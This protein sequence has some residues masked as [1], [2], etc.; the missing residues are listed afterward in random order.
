MESTKCEIPAEKVRLYV[1]EVE[2]ARSVIRRPHQIFD[3]DE[4]GFCLRRI[5]AKKKG[6]VYYK[7]CLT[8]GAFR[9]RPQSREPGGNDPSILAKI[10]TVLS[11]HEHGRN[12][13]SGF[14]IVV[15]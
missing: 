2:H 14:A 1:D 13:G 10:E 7:A 11:H 8:K 9:D 6:N 4:T 12:Q 5:K 3:R 15:N